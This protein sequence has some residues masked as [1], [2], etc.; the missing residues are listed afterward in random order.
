VTHENA[1]EAARK[2]EAESGFPC[3]AVKN[4]AKDDDWLVVIGIS[5]TDLEDYPNLYEDLT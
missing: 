5:Q 1:I 4:P 3:A 2:M